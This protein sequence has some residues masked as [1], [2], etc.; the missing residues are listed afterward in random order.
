[1]KNIN[2]IGVDLAKNVIQISV[3][4]RSNR[5][6][7]NKSLSRKKFAEFLARQAVSLVAFEACATAHYWARAAKRHGHEVK[8]IPAKAVTPFRQGH[9]TDPNDALAVAEA[10]R[11]PNVKLSPLKS[12]DQQSLQSIQRSRE[13][14]VQNRTALSNHVRGI[15][16]EFGIVIPQGFSSLHRYLPEI[17]EDGESELPDMYRS[18]LHLLWRRLCELRDDVKQLTTEI[19]GLVKQEGS[20]K[21]LLALEGVGPIGAVLLFAT[22]GTGEAFVNGRQFSAYL[23]LTPKQFSSGGK[24]NLVGI[25]RHVANKRLRAV[26]IQG[27]RAYV[28]KLKE[29]KSS[30]DRWLMALIERAGTGR[31]S[32]A[33]A[34]KNVRTAWALLTRGTAYEKHHEHALEAA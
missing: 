30:K 24:V 5:E 32:V 23:G 26:L 28:H 19:E 16:M 8:I 9:K 21:R 34:N 33:L 31:A 1:M 10:A 29:P 12:I 13:L 11:R 6:L 2:V 18:T 25:S 7:Q 14:L 27:A 20:C 15:L 17:L 4:S 3:V 22:L